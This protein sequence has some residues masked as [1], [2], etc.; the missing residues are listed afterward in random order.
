MR[1]KPTRSIF[2]CCFIVILSYTGYGQ[3]SG[4]SFD[5][6]LTQDIASNMSGGIKKGQVQLGLINL[7]LSMSSEVLNLWE[8]GTF[9]V[10]IQNTY[11]Q[12]PTENL[13]GDIQVF[14]N[15]ENGTYT[16]LYQLWYSHRI[17]DF[18]ILAGKHD[19]N[20]MFFTSEYAGTYINSSFGI[21]PVASLNV[22]VSIFPMTTL[23]FIGSYDF[24]KQV[25]LMAGVYNGL[26]GNLTQSNFGMDLNLHQSHGQFYVGEFHFHTRIG[27]KTGT[28][29]LGSFYHSGT[30][31]DIMEP[32]TYYQGAAGLYFIADQII[33]GTPGVDGREAGVLFQAGYSPAPGNI[34]DF[35]MAYGLNVMNLL[36]SQDNL[37]I[38]MAHA[39]INDAM[40]NESPSDFADCETAIELTYRFQLLQQLFIQPDFQYIINPGMKRNR[41]NAFAGAFRVQWNIN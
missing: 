18:T 37:G 16:Y 13:I 8:N 20:E 30:F 32:K 39:S 19:L 22:P 1:Y 40:I 35:Y 29:K 7:D 36:Q 4:Y 28:Y 34:N 2:L 11:G 12:L 17:G 5:A 10:Q 21:M 25:T 41:D 15:I 31:E 27:Q 23:G 33:W 38:A 9:R 26:P 14:S 3:N 6:S 24:N